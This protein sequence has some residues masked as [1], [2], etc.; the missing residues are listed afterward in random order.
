MLDRPWAVMGIV[1]VTPDSF[2]DGGEFLRAS[3]AVEHGL[4]MV[5]EGASIL[6]VGGESTR[7]GSRGVDT[8]EEC[9]RVLPVIEQL[10]IRSGVPVSSDTSKSAVARRALDAGATWINDVSGGRFDPSMPVLAGEKRCPVVLMHSRGTPQTMQQNP[11]YGD[12]CREVEDE[13]CVSV[14]RFMEAGV[15]RGNIILDPGIGFAKRLED[16]CRVIRHCNRLVGLGYPVLLGVSRKSF[17]GTLTGRAEPRDRV[18]A[19]LAATVVAF[20]QG[21]R[22]FRVHDVKPAVDALAVAAALLSA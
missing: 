8:E 16:N 12:V 5:D 14:Q 3:D 20:E 2:S 11:A 6:D 13:L 22:L 4:R 15:D 7:P 9:R 1:N 19:G 18:A 10:A 21:V 17:L